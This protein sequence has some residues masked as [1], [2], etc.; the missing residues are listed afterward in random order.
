MIQRCEPTG[1]Q[2]FK[3]C[4][5]RTTHLVLSFFEMIPKQK[6]Q[7]SSNPNLDCEIF[8]F[9]ILLK[10]DYAKVLH[11]LLTTNNIIEDK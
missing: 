6:V 1:Y 10:V 5:E 3:K 8:V 4:G 9:R 11:Q 2:E 7:F